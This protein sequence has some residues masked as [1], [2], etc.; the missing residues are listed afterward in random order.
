M[1]TTSNRF[2][3]LDHDLMRTEAWRVLSPGAIC[4][5]LEIWARHNGRNNG[6][7]VYSNRQAQ[8]RFGCSSKRAVKWF[9][10]LEDKGFIVA[11][12]RGSFN[13]R[14]GALATRASRWRLTMEPSKG[15]QATREYLKWTPANLESGFRNGNTPVSE[16]ETQ[17][18]SGFRNGN[19][20]GPN[21]VSETETLI[22]IL[23][24]EG[25]NYLSSSSASGASAGPVGSAKSP[26]RDGGEGGL[27]QC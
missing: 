1:S 21:P 13:Y 6:E 12:Q 7:I 4:L 2:V 16:T 27:E 3:K 19:R 9:A 18:P 25:G 5:L 8:R 26:D 23:S 11:V 20:I 17:R 14:A 15:S 22:D 24:G 10:E